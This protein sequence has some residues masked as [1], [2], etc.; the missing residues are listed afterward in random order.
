MLLISFTGWWEALGS[1]EQIYWGIALISSAIFVIQ[2]ILTLIGLDADLEADVDGGDG[3]GII[4]LRSLITFTTFFGWG[5]IVAM[6]RDLSTGKVV[7]L[8]FLAGFL[9]MVA[10]AYALS[11]MLKLQESGTV[12]VINAISKEGQVYLRIPVAKDGK[13]MIHVN[14]ENK[15]MEFE[16]ISD[17]AEIPT[18][19][20]V[21]ITDVLNKNVMLVTAIS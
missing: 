14:M 16:A 17:G 15:L 21:R 8:A 18:G 6:E 1:T 12:D 4:S 11:Q 7:M 10:L 19:S 20:K 2:L 13:G 9:A 5:G 3:L